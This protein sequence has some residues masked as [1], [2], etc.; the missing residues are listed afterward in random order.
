MVVGE[1]GNGKTTLL[2]SLINYILG[3]KFEDKFRYKI[4]V[5]NLSSQS[6]S[7]TDEVS[8]YYIASH[9]NYPPLKIIDT[10]GFGDTRGLTRDEIITKLIKDKFEKE[11]DTINAIGFVNKSN[12]V[13]VS[14]YQ[15]YIFGDI[16]NI[17]GKDISEN[18]IFLM[19]FSDY[20]EIPFENALLSSHANIKD[21]I[22]SIKYP[23]YF[24]FN[25][26]AIF[27]SK[28]NKFDELFW[29]LGMKNY[30]GLM[31]KLLSLPSK[32]LILT[33]EVLQ[34]RDQIKY[35]SYLLNN[36]IIRG[37]QILE[38]IQN[39]KEKIDLLKSIIEDSKDYI[40]E[41]DRPKIKV[42]KLKPGEYVTNCLVCNTTCCYPCYIHDDDKFECDVFHHEF[43]TVCPKKCHY[44]EHKKTEYRFEIENIKEKITCKE[45]KRKYFE[46]KNKL[47]ILEQKNDRLN[48]NFQEIQTSC[49]KLQETIKHNTNR[50]KEIS[51]NST[52]SSPTIDYIDSLIKQ[53][54]NIQNPGSLE[55]I[56][57][58]ENLKKLNIDL[59]NLYEAKE[60]KIKEFNK[61]FSE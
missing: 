60:N 56:N 23:W 57:Q 35:S 61:F 10:P 13:R 41:D 49:L 34:K 29:K 9:K 42:I 37:L 7:Q 38:S 5:E 31:Q 32:S 18:F 8:I 17:F 12:Q 28:K 22:K 55:R 2:N 36:E 14:S 4:I 1:T 30:E 54:K 20:N 24:Q 27:S 43:C 16:L 15:K 51:I 50:L 53:E 6:M 58:L 45:L 26:S 21:I 25:N 11:I 48:T 44:S 52:S 40:V 47:S 39:N 46:S 33:N 3:V 59:K 19:T